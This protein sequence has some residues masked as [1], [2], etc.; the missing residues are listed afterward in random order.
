M[1][2]SGSG[3]ASDLF[4]YVEYRLPSIIYGKKY[5]LGKLIDVK[6]WYMDDNDMIDFIANLISYGL[7]RDEYR[8]FVK[9]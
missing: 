6:P 1:G 9:S 2:H 5:L 3:K 8:N 7:V 4:N